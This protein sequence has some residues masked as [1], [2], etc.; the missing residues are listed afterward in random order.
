MSL[1]ATNHTRLLFILLFVELV[2][3]SV[4]FLEID[5]GHAYYV[6][7]KSMYSLFAVLTI[8]TFYFFICAV[9]YCITPS[10]KRL[11]IVSEHQINFLLLGA[12][13]TN[14]TYFFLV[15]ENIRY[16]EGGIYDHML[17]YLLQNLLNYLYGL[18][19]V[20]Q[21]FVQP[22]QPK[23][24][25]SNSLF[26]I[27]VASWAL[28]IDG[29]ASALTLFCFIL[30]IKGR[31]VYFPAIIFAP[32]LVA[33]GS[34]AKFGSMTSIDSVEFLRWVLGR[35]LIN[36]E[37]LFTAQIEPA[38]MGNVIENWQAIFDQINYALNKLLGFDGQW[39]YKSFSELL[40]FKLYGLR[41]GG[42]S[43]GFILSGY[44][45][46]GVTFGAIIV[47]CS[48]LPAV[49]FVHSLKSQISYFECFLF[50]FILKPAICDFP[51]VLSIISTS[52]FFYTLVAVV[53]LL[54]LKKYQYKAELSIK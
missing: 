19:A 48:L 2:F 11:N 17:I 30:L 39:Q 14:C 43:P 40:F 51:G 13:T 22:Y 37:Q 54:G 7:K 10:I 8:T 29:L 18:F 53:G 46:G 5:T 44:M 28:T 16:I 26:Y 4:C 23:S 38:Y 15:G 47:L 42:A 34:M 36:S 41:G 45:L 25:L 52:T 33:A 50:I 20:K 27:W 31:K 3:L 35:F 1:L 9:V 12:T 21:R 24:H 32:I 49:L 6:S